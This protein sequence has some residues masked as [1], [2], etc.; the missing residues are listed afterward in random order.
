MRK[1]LGVNTSHN[2][3]FAYFED[4]ILKEYYEEDRFNKIKNFLPEENEDGNYTYKYKALEKFKDITFDV[5]AFASYDR[6]HLQ[7][8]LP[9][10]KHILKQVK[11]KKYYFD[12]NNHHIY[13]ANC[14]YYFSKFKEAIAV[15]TDGGGEIIHNR[16]F[17]VIQS[18]FT[19]NK[20]QIKKFYQKATNN[21]SYYFND[22]EKI[23][24]KNIT[25]YDFDL[26]LSNA[27]FGGYKYYRYTKK[28]GFKSFEE[29]QL[30][31]IAAYK[32]KNTNLDK[33]VLEIADKAQKE[34]LQEIIELIER[35]KTYSDCKN[36][37]LSGGYHLNCANNFKLVKHFPELNFF[38]DPIPYDGGMAVGAAYYYENYLQ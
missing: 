1:I 12:I 23:I 14:G 3:S 25:D 28:A 13:H 20:E 31:G 27:L 22:N 2:V 5:V 11:Y 7:I 24:E 16:D 36:I 38:V 6:G 4:N 29:G 34:T 17:Q 21:F 33:N 26:I 15:I 8:E 30:M 9:I 32:N 10:I 18:I 35:A 37:I 19:V